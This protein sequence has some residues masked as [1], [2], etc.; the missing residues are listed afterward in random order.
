MFY[1]RCQLEMCITCIE[2]IFT[3]V[4][5]LPEDGLIQMFMLAT[6]NCK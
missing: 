1:L 5:S 6:I 4:D 2:T 3:Y